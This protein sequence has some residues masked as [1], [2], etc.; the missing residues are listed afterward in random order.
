M[1]LLRRRALPRALLLAGFLAAAGPSAPGAP[2]A[3]GDERIPV[4]AGTAT[5]VELFAPPERDGFSFVIFGDRT[6]GDATRYGVWDEG[7]R[8]ANRLDADFV[9]TVGDLIEGYADGETWL[10]QVNELKEHLAALGRPWYPVAGNHDV[11]GGSEN[12]ARG[13]VELYRSHVAPLYYSFDYRWTHFVALFSD[14]SLSFADYARDQNFTAEQLEWL[15]ADLAATKA[16]Q[17]FVFLHHPRWSYPGT[18]WPEV[19]DLLR[20]DGRTRAIFAG[21]LHTWRDDGVSD[22]IHYHVLGSTGG[23]IGDLKESVHAYQIVHVRVRPDGYTASLLPVG[24]VHGADLV[25]RAEVEELLTL[26][27]GGWARIAGGARMALDGRV[28]SPL[29]VEVLNQASRAV[30]VALRFDQG[31]QWTWGG[32]PERRRLLPGE[33]ARL[34][35]VVGA[36]PFDGRVP[37]VG[38]EVAL[39]Y[40]L[41][42]GVEQPV[43]SLLDLPV[44]I[45]GATELAR[46]V[47]DRDRALRVDGA[48]GVRVPF[49]E[50]VAALTLECWVRGRPGE[51]WQGLIGKTQSSGFSLVAHEGRFR[52]NVMVAGGSD[53]VTPTSTTPLDPA[54]WTHC[55]FVWDGATARIFVDGRQ[56]AAAPAA[57]PLAANSLPLFVGAD[58]D[59][60]GDP[61]APFAGEID[62]VRVS[63]VARYAADFAPARRFAPDEDT[64]LL[65]HFDAA[66]GA[67]AGPGVYPDASGREHHGWPVGAPALVEVGP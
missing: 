35:L 61:Q 62:E 24:G 42:S 8:M 22:G 52:G 23:A 60:R 47:S 36:P 53:Y 9:L 39:A 19:H 56:E 65:L 63:R 11:Y 54:R 37:R 12:A 17:I 67:G 50:E 45:A 33:A 15:R 18:N 51:G 48:S 28:E 1:I 21:H 3:P 49:P 7:I 25:Q 66:F 14:E 5:G 44:G 38:I 4:N 34:E 27:R 6:G 30:E 46:A 58:T 16:T 41:A 13:N 32:P 64:L 43:R 10:A 57:G 59:G 29:A 31:G 40:P 2:G 20:Q 26:S 55:A